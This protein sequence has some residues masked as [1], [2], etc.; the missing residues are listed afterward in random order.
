MATRI[1][2]FGFLFAI[3]TFIAMVVSWFAD[4]SKLEADYST[5]S[6]VC[7]PCDPLVNHEL[8]AASF[9]KFS[10]ASHR[11]RCTALHRHR[12]IIHAVITSVT[13]IVVAIPEGLVCVS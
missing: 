4:N 11:S 7:I 8:N 3:L 12:W 6:Y 10:S 1:G 5:S 9:S 13:I 2:Y